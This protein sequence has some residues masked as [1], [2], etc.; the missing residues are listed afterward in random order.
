[1]IR[2][3]SPTMA[4]QA[5]AFTLK[6]DSGPTELPMVRLKQSYEDSSKQKKGVSIVDGS[7]IVASLYV[8]NKFN[9]GGSEHKKPELG[10]QASQNNQLCRA[11]IAI[12]LTMF[13]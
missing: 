9:H 4:F 11:G 6:R 12:L 1:M 8:I 3:F 13:C 5:P 10:V 2:T 7:S